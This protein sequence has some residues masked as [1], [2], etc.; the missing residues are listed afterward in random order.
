M[1]A[2]ILFLN[3]LISNMRF[4][5][6]FG[7]PGSGKS[8]LT[9]FLKSN[10]SKLK[11][12]YSFIFFRSKS[13]FSFFRKIGVLLIIFPLNLCSYSFYKLLNLFIFI[14]RPIKSKFISVRT[15][16]L[17]LNS[18]YFISIIKIFKILKK[19][20][21]VIDQGFFQ[22]LWSILYE[23]DFCESSSHKYLLKKWDE[24]LALLH[25]DY[26]I[27]KCNVESEV[28]FQRIDERKGD[29]IIEEELRNRIYIKHE[30]IFQFIIDTFIENAKNKKIYKIDFIDTTKIE[31]NKII[32]FIDD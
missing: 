31:L 25:L 28:L 22:L 19:D 7:I 8:Y 27:L 9:E 24:I 3:S 5:E 15:I 1:I 2:F 21:I 26:Y 13:Y 29:S 12:K 11:K 14:Y 18:L 6:F 30:K 23:I 20:S 4:I 16:K 32:K 10:Q 17:F